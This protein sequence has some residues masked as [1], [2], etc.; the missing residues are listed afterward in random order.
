MKTKTILLSLLCFVGITTA[1][2]QSDVYYWKDG[3][4]VK[5]ETVDSLTFKAPEHFDF[6]AQWVDLGLSVKW[7]RINVGATGMTD[8]GTYFAWGETTG[9]TSDTN[10][11]KNNFEWT[12]RDVDALVDENLILLPSYDA[13]HANWGGSWRMPTKEEFQELKDNCTWTWYDDYHHT[14][15]AGYYIASNKPG[16]TDNYI[17]LPAGDLFVGPN[18]PNPKKEHPIGYYWSSTLHT[19]GYDYAFY[20]ELRDSRCVVDEASSESGMLVRPVLAE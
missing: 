14:G 12:E 20:L 8:Y 10:Y 3:K 18:K 1:T 16:F 6:A 17:F 4:A 19:H 11:A 15:V 9:W 2:A 13:A 7:A 5:L